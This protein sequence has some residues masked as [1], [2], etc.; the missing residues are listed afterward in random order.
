MIISYPLWSLL[1]LLTD[2]AASWE[3]KESH[4]Q[5]RRNIDWFHLSRNYKYCSRVL[6]TC[7]VPDSFLASVHNCRHRCW[8]RWSIC[9]LPGDR[10]ILL[11]FSSQLTISKMRL[12]SLEISS[13]RPTV[14]QF[15]GDDDGAPVLNNRLLCFIK[16][17]K[18]VHLLVTEFFFNVPNECYREPLL[19]FDIISVIFL[20]IILSLILLP[21]LLS[22][23]WFH[24][25]PLKT[26]LN[27]LAEL[28]RRSIPQTYRKTM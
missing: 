8:S 24:L 16:Q 2:L 9:R 11:D 4:K 13:E 3:S 12:C 15:G 25:I 22:T 21:H 1:W 28:R 19:F 20:G 6:V 23:V 14:L 27:D 18:K 17:W 5:A 26:Y 7:N 10:M